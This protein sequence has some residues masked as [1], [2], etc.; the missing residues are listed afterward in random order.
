M[1]SILE[2]DK[3]HIISLFHSILTAIIAQPLSSRSR[4]TCSGQ[5]PQFFLDGYHGQQ[6]GMSP[7]DSVAT[8]WGSTPHTEWL[9]KGHGGYNANSS[10]YS[11][12]CP[13]DWLYTG[14]LL[15]LVLISFLV[16]PRKMLLLIRSMQSSSSE[17]SF[18]GF[19]V[20][21]GRNTI[22]YNIKYKIQ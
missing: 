19:S 11:L 13:Q 16:D 17:S 6:A 8:Q 4:V 10:I 14:I 15:T 1:A 12:P 22:K 21:L 5:K 18:W 20:C 7:S 3:R 2:S 9:R